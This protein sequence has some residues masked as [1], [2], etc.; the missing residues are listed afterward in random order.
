MTESIAIVGTHKDTLLRLA[1]VGLTLPPRRSSGG[2][3][4]ARGTCR[5][6]VVEIRST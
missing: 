3:L 6:I 4:R 1:E 5:E 2:Q